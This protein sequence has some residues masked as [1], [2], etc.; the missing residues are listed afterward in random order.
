MP[1]WSAQYGQCV[2]TD[3]ARIFMSHDQRCKMHTAKAISIVSA[4]FFEFA[5]AAPDRR[6]CDSHSFVQRSVAT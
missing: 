5:A 1:H 2:V 4:G 6:A 3:S